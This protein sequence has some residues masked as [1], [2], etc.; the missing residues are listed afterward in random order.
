M[1]IGEVAVRVEPASYLS[2]PYDHLSPAE[3]Y[4]H[5][6]RDRALF[7]L[8]RR[9]GIERLSGVR[10]VELGCGA[11]FLMRSLVHYGARSVRL[12]GV[13][14]QAAA[15]RQAHVALPDAAV[16]AADAARLP[17]RSDVFDLAFAFT[18]FSSMLDA[19][20]RRRAAAEAM[21]V[22]RPGGLLVLY[23]F[24]LN[25]TNRRVHPVGA[26]EL[27]ALFAPRSVEIERVTLAPPIV[28]A[29]GGRP[30]LCAPLERLLFLRTHL[31]AAVRKE[32]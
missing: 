16:A 11:G 21:R 25:P 18:S 22:L 4:L 6:S 30:A 13:D 3:R 32:A 20:A 12:A 27:R 26:A 5:T 8:F 2:A 31:L 7:D 9:H 23:D 1:T 29:L 15:V 28:R 14:L 17:F 10:A 19:G 24:S